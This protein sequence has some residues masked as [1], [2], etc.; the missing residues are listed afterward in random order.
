VPG[1]F[2]EGELEQILLQWFGDLGYGAAFGPDMLPDQPH[3]ERHR[4]DEAFLPDRVRS[5]LGRLNPAL[6]PDAIE[7]A[8][9]KVTIPDSPSLIE[10]NHRFHRM[11]TDGVDVSTRT[12]EGEDAYA[13]AW[14]FDFA[15][16]ALRVMC[17][18]DK[19]PG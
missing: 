19:R 14:L 1:L 18:V 11:L 16:P 2:S 8:F 6:P 7:E 3:A 17:I 10:S 4:L 9:R 15:D 5:A 12:G 13:K